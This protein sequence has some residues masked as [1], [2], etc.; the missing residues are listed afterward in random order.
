MGLLSARGIF[1]GKRSIIKHVFVCL[2]IFFILNFTF[3]IAYTPKVLAEEPP[4][5]T[6]PAA[7][8]TISVPVSGQWQMDPEV[9]MIGKNAERARQLL[10]WVFSHP[11]IHTAPVLAQLWAI[12]RN[13]VYIFIVI[14]LVAYGVGLIISRRRGSLGPLY[15]GMGPTVFGFNIP[16][17]FFKLGS[18]LL[19]ATFSYLMVLVL[20]QTSDIVMKFFIEN[21]GGKD[22]FNVIFSGAGNSDANYTSFIGYRDI[23]LQNFE[24]AK[25][26]IAII[27]FSSLTYY[28]IS[29]ILILR[30]IILWLMLVL[31]PFLALLMPF[32]FIRNVGWI[33]VG[34]FFQWLFYGPVVALFLAAVTK[35]WVAGIP[36]SFDFSRVNKPEGQVY[37]TA[38]NI[39][40]GGPAQIVTAGNSANYIDTFAEYLISL[41]MLWAAMILPWLLL[42]IFRDYCCEAIATG[43]AALTGILDRIR[44]Y[45]PPSPELPT[46]PV[47]STG[48]AVELPFR[49][50]VEERIKEIKTTRVENIR[51]IQNENTS[52]L[53]RSLDLAVNSLADLS[54]LDMNQKMRD[55][56]AESLRRIS[57][58]ADLS[59]SS[60]RE[61]YS[62]LRQELRTRAIKGDHL[63]RAMLDAAADRKESIASQIMSTST[64]GAVMGGRLSVSE[65]VSGVPVFMPT[66]TAASSSLNQTR[67]SEIANMSGL[68]E[69]KTREILEKLPVSGT[70]TTSVITSIISS[71]VLSVDTIKDVLQAISDVSTPPSQ[72][73]QKISQKS[74]LGDQKIYEIWVAI[75]EEVAHD[76]SIMSDIARITN[77]DEGNIRNIFQ[78]IP[79]KDQ[80]AGRLFTNLAVKSGFTREKMMEVVSSA[81]THVLN[82]PKISEKIAQKSDLTNDKVREVITHLGKSTVPA[83]NVISAIAGVSGV[84]AD[85]TLE[86]I[87][88]LALAA[89]SSL[90]LVQSAMNKTSLSESKIREVME[91]LHTA[92]APVNEFIST[93]A[94][95]S[96]LSSD[97]VLEIISS[98][99][100]SAILESTVINQ[101]AES[102]GV[103]ADKVKQVM[104]LSGVKAETKV[105]VNVSIEDYEEVKKM[106]L[107][108]YREAPV[109]VSEVIKTR[110]DWLSLEEK[111]LYSIIELMNSPDKKKKHQGLAQVA[112]I[113]PFM[114][115]G[116]FSETEIITYLKAKHEAVKLVAAEKEAEMRLKE[117]VKKEIEE[118]SEENMVA[119]G[120]TQVTEAKEE[121]E[122]SASRVRDDMSENNSGDR[123]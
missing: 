116:G 121:K 57:S 43:N 6:P 39:L 52:D 88:S 80:D 112:E 65:K 123:Q 75:S 91:N 8:P 47:T 55:Q 64:S 89:S 115:L 11:G 74:G 107:K 94:H 36:Y 72:V 110:N 19:Y 51:N 15:A 81:S 103:T 59:T 45:P 21:V 44:Q 82:M 33:W 14:V 95:K 113:L 35:I 7:T 24:S 20:I 66:S 104:N 37:R 114:L 78:A 53:A 118:N 40:Y 28:I 63:A 48:M 25:T 90:A 18:I 93:I 69:T 83:G 50:R 67:I 22:L 120:K 9:T 76:S 10:F 73:I 71:L 31:S 122:L 46:A 79:D 111:K 29:I 4:T 62:A 77:L 1:C 16:G 5:S 23:S 84:T 54:K 109:P 26:S 34:V 86:V 30:T 108:H 98:V 100:S 12:S 42:R 119:V 2:A 60:D 101:I 68:S 32:V 49:R 85:K 17:I 106:W 97:K 58:P 117:E 3:Y 61:K 38:I 105:G 27:N 92:K 99:S 102:M 13:I 70:L 96:N 56:S 41:I 87:S